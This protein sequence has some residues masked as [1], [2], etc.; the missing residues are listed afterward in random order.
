MRLLLAFFVFQVI[1]QTASISSVW[2]QDLP[3]PNPDNLD[4]LDNLEKVDLDFLTDRIKEKTT[5]VNTRSLS[6]KELSSSGLQQ[7]KIKMKRPDKMLVV[8]FRRG[9]PVTEMY[10]N[11]DMINIYLLDY[12]IVYQQDVS[13]RKEAFST[14]NADYL[15]SLYDFSFFDQETQKNLFSD[16]ERRRFNILNEDLPS[17]YH[18]RLDPKDKT[19]GLDSIQL[20]VSQDGMIRKTS[21]VDIEGRVVEFY[22]YEI[23]ENQFISDNEF[24]FVLPADVRVVK[25]LVEPIEEDFL[26]E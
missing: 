13:T 16:E 18:L 17:V 5:K 26:K 10:M 25:N 3:Q 6:F 15:F 20:W 4:D 24:D 14:F 9:E 12:K 7:G 1:F 21:S 23:E 22:F 2:A 11:D 19:F 8:Y